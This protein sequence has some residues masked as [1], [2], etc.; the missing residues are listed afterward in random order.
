MRVQL[1]PAY[2]LHA[3]PW[4]ETSLLLECLTRD[5][6]RIGL[7]ARGVRGAR[8]RG[9]GRA[10]LEPFRLLALDFLLRGE[11]GTLTAVEVGLPLPLSGDALLAGLYLNEL[12]VRLSGRQDPHPALFAAYGEA[13]VRLSA[14]AALGWTL[15]RFE[16]DLLGTLGYA[17]Q[18]EREID[19]G[20]PVL[21]E[22][23]YVYL[24][25]HGPQRWQGQPG[26]RVSGAALLALAADRE[27]DAVAQ[28]ELR[29]LL[30]SLISTVLGGAELR[31]RRVLGD[32]LRG[33]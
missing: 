27:P 9:G 28:A 21:P 33:R 12:T 20:A 18:L 1:Q 4:R 8:A 13:L 17:P 5:H 19:S 23:A 31:S 2:V 16:R 29:R 14:G 10:A 32:A 22:E 26:V 24:P 7:V 30:R 6:G 11:L 15:R 3:R 25:E